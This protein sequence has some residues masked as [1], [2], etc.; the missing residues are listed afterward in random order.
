MGVYMKYIRKLKRKKIFEIVGLIVFVV[1]S[2]YLW[3]FDGLLQ[4]AAYYDNNSLI[5]VLDD[6]TYSRILY[7]LG[8]DVANKY[9]SDYKLTLVNNTY[10]E[11]NYNVYLAISNDIDHSHIKIKTDDVKYL[12]ELYSFESDGYSYYLLDSN[13]LQGDERKYNFSLYNDF[14][15]DTFVP[16]DLKI[17]LE[18]I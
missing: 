12:N 3:E 14:D 6:P 10:R 11:E 17:K 4:T 13:M 9:L 1:L 5:E 7:A 18:K 16:Y 2:Y 15:G 8:D